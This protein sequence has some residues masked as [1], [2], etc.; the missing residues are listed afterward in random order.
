MIM[1]SKHW[2]QQLR[3]IV[4]YFARMTIAESQENNLFREDPYFG[5]LR[6]YRTYGRVLL[7]LREVKH[8]I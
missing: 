7:H 8:E 6:C 3:I 4:S 1:E 2:E 5:S